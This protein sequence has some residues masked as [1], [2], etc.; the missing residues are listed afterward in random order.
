[1]QSTLS[2]PSLNWIIWNKTVLTL[3]LCIA[4]L[5]GA[6]EYTTAPLQKD[7]TTPNDCPGYDTLQSDGEVPSDAGGLGNAEYPFITIAPRSTLA[8]NG[9]TW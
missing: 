9:S 4:Q 1:M 8:Q 3:T 6:V 2:L 5:A 7:K